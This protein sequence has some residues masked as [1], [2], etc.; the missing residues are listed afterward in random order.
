MIVV[1]QGTGRDPKDQWKDMGAFGRLGVGSCGVISF[2]VHG[3][4][5]GRGRAKF[6]TLF[7][8]VHAK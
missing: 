2:P 7:L 1:A 8:R 4:L 5:S 3:R 6:P